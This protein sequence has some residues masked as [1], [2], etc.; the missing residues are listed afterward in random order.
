MD[1]RKGKTIL[2]TGATGKQG[3][4]VF[5]KL[6]RDGWRVRAL[7]RNPAS[8]AAQRLEH[9]GAELFHGDLEDPE[10]LRRACEG[11]Y[12]VFGVHTPMEAGLEAEVRHGFNLAE[13][14][15]RAGVRHYLYSSVGGAD[16]QSGVPFYE[17]KARIEARVLGLGLPATILRPVF[18]MENFN[19]PA[20]RNSIVHGV[21]RMPLK[22]DRPLQ[23]IA[24][25][26]IGTFAALVFDRPEEYL[27]RALEI[28]GDEV[29][30]EEAAGIFSDATGGPVEYE[31][32]PLD[33]LESQNPSMAAM[34]RWLD[35]SGYR[36]DLAHLRKLCPGLLSFRAWALTSWIKV[37]EFEAEEA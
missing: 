6:H 1:D 22:R 20:L 30:M 4:M 37:G 25:D 34:Y 28:A 32:I 12:G 11:V 21:L 2:V 35:R 13:A 23:M 33:F 16:R 26:D 5:E 36:A 24:V 3:R 17:T 14:A 7:A 19:D 9:E 8:A 31:A 18:F 29:T 10:S 27:G 15:A